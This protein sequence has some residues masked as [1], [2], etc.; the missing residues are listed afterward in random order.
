MKA[1][2][3][4]TDAMLLAVHTLAGIA[5]TVQVDNLRDFAAVFDRA[6]TQ[7]SLTPLSSDEEQLIEDSIGITERMLVEALGLAEPTPA[8][9]MFDR[10]EAI[11][12]AGSSEPQ[13]MQAEEVLVP[14]EEAA[15]ERDEQGNAIL[16]PEPAPSVV[17]GPAV[18]EVE[19]SEEHTSELQSH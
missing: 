12:N 14:E 13:V 11:A 1:H 7:L 8:P 9:E 15:I 19:R 2:G 4:I 16:P 6:L 17:P 3:V 10:L 5:G 18:V